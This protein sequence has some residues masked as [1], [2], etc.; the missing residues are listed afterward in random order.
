[1][2]ENTNESGDER[3]SPKFEVE[4]FEGMRVTNERMRPPQPPDDVISCADDIRASL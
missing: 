4:T 1:M 2:V 3:H